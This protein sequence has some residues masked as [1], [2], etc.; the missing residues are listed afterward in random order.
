MIKYHNR[1]SSLAVTG[2]VTINRT[3]DFTYRKQ[4]SIINFKDFFYKHATERK[5]SLKYVLMLNFK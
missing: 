2:N 4:F 3:V 1:R 5:Y